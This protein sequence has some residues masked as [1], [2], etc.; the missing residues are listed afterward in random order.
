LRIRTLWVVISPRPRSSRRK[1]PMLEYNAP[2]SSQFTKAPPTFHPAL[3]SVERC[4]RFSNATLRP[5]QP[6]HAGRSRYSRV[7]LPAFLLPSA[8]SLFRVSGGRAPAQNPLSLPAARLP[9]PRPIELRERRSL[10]SAHF[11]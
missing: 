7:A 3:K 1:S 2:S 4:Q 10:A 8:A 9:V 5:S 6:A 11:R